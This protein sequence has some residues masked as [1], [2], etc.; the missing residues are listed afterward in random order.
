MASVSRTIEQSSIWVENLSMN[1]VS[2]QSVV[3]DMFGE[4]VLWVKAEKTR[5]VY[6]KG[7]QTMFVM[8]A[9]LLVLILLVNA[10]IMSFI[11]K[12]VVYRLQK[13]VHDMKAISSEQNL[14]LRVK[15]TGM[16]EVAELEKEFNK[17][18][19]SLEASQ[20]KV[21]SKLTWIR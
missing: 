17:M 13:L 18:M 2:V 16:D 21:R 7:R 12:H 8:A 15:V 5:D 3:H 10:A 20:D 1:H 9:M 11:N 14:S 6:L 19:V 4:P